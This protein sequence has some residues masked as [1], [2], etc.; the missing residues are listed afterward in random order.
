MLDNIK[1]ENQIEL[2]DRTTEDVNYHNGLPD[3]TVAPV[4][5][6][7]SRSTLRTAA[8][9]VA[10]AVSGTN[11]LSL[12]ASARME[13]AFQS[14]SVEYFGHE[15]YHNRLTFSQWPLDGQTIHC[16]FV[17]SGFSRGWS[18]VVLIKV[19]PNSCWGEWSDNKFASFTQ[20]HHS[21]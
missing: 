18:F 21:F 9:L 15:T 14:S 1:V 3:R 11:I 10:L 12:P 19:S 13:G 17:K 20:R 2:S 5:V 6:C 16:L 7:E 8:I 4:E